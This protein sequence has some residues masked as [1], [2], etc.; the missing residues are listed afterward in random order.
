MTA[1]NDSQVQFYREWLMARKID[2]SDYGVNM[3]KEEFTDQMV[4]EFGVAFRG[5][6]TIDEMLLHPR[7]AMKFCDDVKHKH[8]Y[9]SV[10][11]DVI[12]RVLITKRKNPSS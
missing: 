7:D 11:D 3:T 1:V 2:P 12:L 8:G 6:W 4:D 9:F 5:A 10:P